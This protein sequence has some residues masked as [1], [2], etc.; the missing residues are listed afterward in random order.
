MKLL[1]EIIELSEYQ[2]KEGNLLELYELAKEGVTRELA[3]EKL[4]KKSSNFRNTYKVL[5]DR[6]LDGLLE[7]K[8]RHFSYLQKAHFQLLDKYVKARILLALGKNR[9]G[10]I[11]AEE[12]VRQAEKLELFLMVF[13]ISL[14]LENKFAISGHVKFNKYREKLDRVTFL[15]EAETK[16]KRIENRLN[17]CMTKSRPVDWVYE[18]IK[19]LDAIFPTNEQFNFRLQYYSIKNNICFIENNTD[20]LEANCAEALAFFDAYPTPIPYVTKF[21]FLT[22]VIPAYVVNKEYERASANLEK[23]IALTQHVVGGWNWHIAQLYKAT[24]AFYNNDP[25]LA[26]QVFLEVQSI[27]KRFDNSYIEARWKL[28][29]AYLSLYEQIGKIS[30][31]PPFRLYRLLN[32]VSPLTG[33]KT[34]PNIFILELLHLLAQ[35]KHRRYL[36]RTDGI[37]QYLS[38]NAKVK[39]H[40]RLRFFMRMLRSI[41]LGAF[42]SVRV[43]AH[44]KKNKVK[45]LK[46]SY[47]TNMDMLDT[48]VV[49]Y[50]ILWELA[51]ALLK[52]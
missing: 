4:K 15:L 8:S 50:E 40:T 10:I 25:A 48:E 26:L 3:E 43:N 30:G 14:M 19:T 18:E 32:E 6:L 45:L 34:K 41:S 11:I 12:V 33:D 22:K 16:A 29:H 28:I 44:A 35:E 38:R 49:P 5:K 21:I 7:H 20:A 2:P 37:E 42:H 51:L 39:H 9:S 17:F 46:T 31:V 52:K 24:I 47:H 1:Q 36:D 23:C 27:R 13:E